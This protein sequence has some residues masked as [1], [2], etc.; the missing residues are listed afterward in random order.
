MSYYFH[1]LYHQK[2]YFRDSLTILIFQQKAFFHITAK[3]FEWIDSDLFDIDIGRLQNLLFS[4]LFQTQLLTLMYDICRGWS[5]SLF[6]GLVVH[7]SRRWYI[8][9]LPFLLL[10][11][12][13]RFDAWIVNTNSKT[14]TI[15]LCT[16]W[17]VFYKEL[18]TSKALCMKVTMKTTLN[19]LKFEL[20]N[21]KSRIQERPTRVV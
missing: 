17:N 8:D 9:N 12:T 16:K 14:L 2:S 20:W 19:M 21:H 18:K 7:A 11:I 13:M 4:T 5:N 6:E 10:P 3:S 15:W 1:F